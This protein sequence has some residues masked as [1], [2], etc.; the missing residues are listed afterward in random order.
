LN[1]KVSLLVAGLLIGGL[2]G[3]LTRPEAAQINL[4]PVSIEVQS[5]RAA[6]PR[7]GGAMTTGQWQHVGAFAIGG[8]V[9]GLLAGFAVDRRRR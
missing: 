8:A 5:D 6:S 1:L 7:S 9:L 4:G 3:Y 2:V